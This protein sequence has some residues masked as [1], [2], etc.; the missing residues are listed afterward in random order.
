M[1]ERQ[2]VDL[3]KVRLIINCW[4]GGRTLSEDEIREN[5]GVPVAGTVALDAKACLDSVNQQALLRDLHP[6]SATAGD[7]SNLVSLITDKAERVLP[8]SSGG[9]L[10]W[11]F[12]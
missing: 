10:G 11:L 5:L 3:H 1:L 2:G 7:I 8:S 12:K 4:D 6:R 9:R